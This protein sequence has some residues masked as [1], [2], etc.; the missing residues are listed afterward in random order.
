MGRIDAIITDFDGTLVNTF[1][2]NY[3]AYK[4]VLKNHKIELTWN[5]YAECFGLRF[6]GLCDKLNIPKEIRNT[7]K[8]EKKK[9][10]PEFFYGILLNENLMRFIIY[11]KAIGIKTCIASTA[12]KENLYNVLDYFKIKDYFDLIITG[13]DVIWG[14]PNPEVYNKALEKLNV[15]KD[16]ALV[17]EDSDMG[18]LAAYDAGINYIDV[19]KLK[20]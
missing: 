10:Y 17:F 18:C 14:K 16:C 11:A 20:K 6:D 15:N 7:I 13:E 4:S 8:E 12:S 1:S 3:L 9:V 5:Q 2:A 19:N